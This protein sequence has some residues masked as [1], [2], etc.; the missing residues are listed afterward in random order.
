MWTV[1][2]KPEDPVRV[3]IMFASVLHGPLMSLLLTCT[4]A[5][6]P[7]TLLS[8]PSILILPMFTF[9]TFRTTETCWS[10]KQG[11]RM[12]L[13]MSL[14]GTI[15][16]VC[17]S[18]VGFIGATVLMA[19][20]MGLRLF[21]QPEMA[22]TL[23]MVTLGV[24]LTLFILLMSYCCPTSCLAPPLQFNVYRPHLDQT[25]VWRS[26]NSVVAEYGLK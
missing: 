14:T 13:V 12:G 21:Q 20:Y 22:L 25:P 3:V 9:Y 19:A 18:L 7:R 16:N 23:L 8:H 15:I 17:I 26:E 2:H 10:K 1:D 6:S 11:D 24:T 4:F 5:S